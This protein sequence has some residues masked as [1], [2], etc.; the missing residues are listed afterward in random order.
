MGRKRLLTLLAGLVMATGL[1][2]APVA[3]QD[4]GD[5]LGDTTDALTGG[6]GSSQ[7][8]GSGGGDGDL[9]DVGDALDDV[10][11][12]LGVDLDSSEEAE[13]E[14]L[15][16]QDPDLEVTPSSDGSVLRVA[17]DPVVDGVKIVLE[18]VE[19]TADELTGGGG[20]EG[21][22]P[23]PEPEPKP[24]PE[25][26]PEQNDS[27]GD[28]SS[29]GNDGSS[30]QQD[31]GSSQGGSE[32]SGDSGGSGGSE[33]SGSGGRDQGQDDDV[34]AAGE[35]QARDQRRQNLLAALGGIQ[36][37]RP[38]GGNTA[39]PVAPGIEQDESTPLDAFESLDE[40][41]VA[42]GQDPAV[43]PQNEDFSGG[44]VPGVSD[45][46]GSQDDGDREEATIAAQP[47][48]SS[49]ESSQVPV[50]LQ[51]LAGTLVLGRAGAWTV[52]R[53][54]LAPNPIASTPGR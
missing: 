35:R 40:P 41:E 30:G 52:A 18:K 50:A 8:D 10:T 36:S 13:L 22:E 2:V 1:S 54:E 29:S 43:A 7:D 15:V 14:Q 6:D 24:D 4:L 37:G 9:L 17:G 34:E 25:P 11:S 33:S 47:F 48:D 49:D 16:E 53:R 31:Q 42:D 28:D 19:E 39:G 5:T 12:G 26:E 27:G 20:D 3:A 32:P 45:D 23:E 44:V 21:S 51:L 38:A 46:P